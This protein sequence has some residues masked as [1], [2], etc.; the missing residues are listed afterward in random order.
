MARRY[1]GA[2]FRIGDRVR[3]A[4]SS[5]QYREFSPGGYVVRVTEGGA[6]VVARMD[7][8]RLVRQHATM[9]F[10]VSPPSEAED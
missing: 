5:G 9:W 8:G 2:R 4:R 7:D 1:N 6:F 3:L 10:Y